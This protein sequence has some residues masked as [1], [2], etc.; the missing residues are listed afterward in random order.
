MLRPWSTRRVRAGLAVERQVQQQHVHP[1]LAETPAAPLRCARSQPSGPRRCSGTRGRGHAGCLHERILGADVRVEAGADL[2]TASAGH[3]GSAGRS[4]LAAVRRDEVPGAF[5]VPSRIGGPVR[6]RR[7]VNTVEELRAE[8]PRFVPLELAAS[9]PAPAADGRGW[10]YRASAKF[11]PISAEPTAS[12][13]SLVKPPAPV[14]SEPF[15]WTGKST[16]AIPHTRS[17]YGPQQ[18]AG[19]PA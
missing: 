5:E 1:R 6:I 18:S 2:V 13:G 4:I 19:T 12:S 10:K 17:G 9:Y 14:T 11:C 3:R 8:G 15:A 16:C 7:A